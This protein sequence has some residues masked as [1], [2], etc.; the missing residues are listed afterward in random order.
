MTALFMLWCVARH[1]TRRTPV[2]IV[3]AGDVRFGERGN[4][5]DKHATGPSAGRATTCGTTLS[6]SEACRGRLV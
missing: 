4:R 2:C 3:A 6:L 1:T 5:H